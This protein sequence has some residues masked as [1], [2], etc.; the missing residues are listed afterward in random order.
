ME[1][2]LKD[3]QCQIP[4]NFAENAIHLF[5]AGRK[6]WLFWD[7]AEGAKASAVIYSIVETAKANNLSVKD[8]LRVLLEILPEWDVRQHPENMDALLLWGEYIQDRFEQGNCRIL[9]FSTPPFLSRTPGYWAVTLRQSHVSQIRKQTD[10]QAAALCRDSRIFETTVLLPFLALTVMH[11][12][13]CSILK[14]V[15]PTTGCI[16]RQQSDASDVPSTS[17]ASVQ[18]LRVERWM[19]HI[20]GRIV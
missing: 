13:R 9:S 12:D 18:G 20:P 6:N 11:T 4:N 17:S 10:A 15:R 2:H 16:L 5:T 1:N 3:S 19:V 14:S 8:Y 7:I